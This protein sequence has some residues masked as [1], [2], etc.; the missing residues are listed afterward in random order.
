[1]TANKQSM[2]PDWIDE[3]EAP[4]LSAPRLP[5][6]ARCRSLRRGRPKAEAPKIST[7]V[8]LDA[9]IVGHISAPAAPAGNPA[10]TPPYAPR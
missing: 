7:T 8:R 10:S 3:D 1:M 9:D 4:D 2:A 6:E 5:R